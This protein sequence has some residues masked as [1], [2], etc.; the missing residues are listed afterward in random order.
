MVIAHEFFNWKVL[1]QTELFKTH[2]KYSDTQNY[3]GVFTCS[4]LA[5]IVT[6]LIRIVIIL[7][8]IEPILEKCVEISASIVT[9]LVSFG[10][11]LMYFKACGRSLL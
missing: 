3:K 4:I 10:A 2:W 5:S 6:I 7:L 1:F 11:I 9:I 8:S